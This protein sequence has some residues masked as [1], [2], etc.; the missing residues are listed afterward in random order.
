MKKLSLALILLSLLTIFPAFSQNDQDYELTG[1]MECTSITVGKKA[2]AD[3]SVYTSH[4]DDSHRTRTNIV[5]VPAQDHPTGSVVKMYKRQ[6][7]KE[8][9]G[10][11]SHYENIEVGTIPQVSH[12]YKYFSTAYPCMNEKQVA[13]GESTFSPRSELH[14]DTG[15]IDCQRLCQLILERCSTARQAIMVAGDL[16]KKYGWIDGGEALTIADKNEVWHLE[17]VGPGKGKVG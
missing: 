7:A 16:L 10:K 11:M 14:S 8:E 5:V 1:L 15:L 3:G 2:S 6:N 4:T 17:I 13:I 12:T 9:Y